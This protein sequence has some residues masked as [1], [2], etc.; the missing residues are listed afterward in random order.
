MSDFITPQEVSDLTGYSKGVLS[1]MRN[2]KE[3]FPF[4]KM[5]RKVFYKKSEVLAEIEKTRVDTSTKAL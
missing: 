5:G 2:K 4:Y 3:G 1:N